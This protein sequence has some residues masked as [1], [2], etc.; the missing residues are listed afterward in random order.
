MVER[1]IS[2]HWNR[3]FGGLEDA[4]QYDGPEREVIYI[5]PYLAKIEA[6]SHDFGKGRGNPRLLWASPGSLSRGGRLKAED[7]LKQGAELSTSVLGVESES[8]ST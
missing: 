8:N 2:N 7:H 6:Q 4:D 1:F 5:D 3:Y